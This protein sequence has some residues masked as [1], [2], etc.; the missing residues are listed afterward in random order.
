MS[1][2]GKENNKLAVVFPGIGYHKDKPL[3]YYSA[4]LVA[5]MGYDVMSIG[6]HEMV[7][8]I[9]GNAEMMR[10][11]AELAYAQ[12]AEQLAGVRFEELE[13][14]LFIGKSIGTVALARYAAEHQ[15]KA[16]QIWYTPVEATFS[17]A[18]KNVIAFIGDADPWS[19]VSNIHSMAGELG[20]ELHSYPGCNH[21]LECD[22]VD[23]NIANLR[24]VMLKTEAF[25]RR[26]LEK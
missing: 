15:I 8:K 25:C 22:S 17:F 3:L 5:G 16:G 26:G 1:M 14:I 7:R 2:D 23:A 10:K 4:K 6:Y 9:R 24:D 21:S 20:I 18:S 12:G 19:D 13:D 11:A